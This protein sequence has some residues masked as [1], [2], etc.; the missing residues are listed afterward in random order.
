MLI[1]VQMT[2]FF[3]PCREGQQII[4]T[5]T[6]GILIIFTL[7]FEGQSMAVGHKVHKC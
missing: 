5:F 6:E 4:M 7:V 1:S 2:F 3:L